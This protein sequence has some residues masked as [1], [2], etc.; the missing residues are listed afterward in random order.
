MGM[1]GM[2]RFFFGFFYFLFL[3]TFFYFSFSSAISGRVSSCDVLAVWR[4]KEQ[5]VG[6]I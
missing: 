5:Q 1:L 3:P 6:D 4:G 2:F